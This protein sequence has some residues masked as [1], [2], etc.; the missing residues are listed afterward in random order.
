MPLHR[1]LQSVSGTCRHC[2][3]NASF[4]RKQHGQCR[5]TH[6]SGMN[7]MTQL[8][9]QAAGTS[10]FNETAL[11][12]TLQAIADRARATPD[13]I[14]QAIAT[15]FAQGVKHAMQDGTLTQE[16][17]TNLRAFRDRMADQDLPSVITGSTTLD[18]ASAD[19][20]TGMATRT[21]LAHGGGGT[22]QELDN[23][24]RRAM[25]SNTHRRQL[26]I[27]P[28]RKRSKGPSRTG[29]YPSTRRTPCPSTWTTSTSPPRTST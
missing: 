13:D 1:F 6:Q 18:R 26:L 20:I 5:Q 27:R 16:E 23:A 2:G 4:L 15:G 28:G 24:L 21:T 12:S 19:R 22:L 11:R 14:S 29:F 8:A 10:S 3:Q 9:A 7:E 25:M 17:E